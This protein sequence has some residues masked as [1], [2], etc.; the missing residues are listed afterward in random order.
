MSI[1]KDTNKTFHEDCFACGKNSQIGLKLEFQLLENKT[2]FG[3]FTMSDDYQG[4]DN[5]L[6]GG[7]IST[8]LDSSMVNL[9]YLKDGLELKTAKLNLRFIKPIPVTGIMSIYAIVDETARHFYKAK[10]KIMINDKVFAKAEGYF[11]K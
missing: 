8:I 1:N 10:S 2:L 7:I 6:H 5:I 4:Y 3:T 11:R 9:F